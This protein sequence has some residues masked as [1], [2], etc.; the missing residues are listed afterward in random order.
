MSWFLFV[1]KLALTRPLP[2]SVRENPMV[3]AEMLSRETGCALDCCLTQ[4]EWLMQRSVSEIRDIMCEDD[5]SDGVDDAA[6]GSP[7]S[8]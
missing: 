8:I 6:R 7:L 2:A 1:N 5:E 3:L 4:V